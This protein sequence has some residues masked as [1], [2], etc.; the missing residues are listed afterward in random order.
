MLRA[1]TAR[2]IALVTPAVCI[3]PMSPWTDAQ[4]NAV[5]EI[6]RPVKTIGGA[7]VWCIG[8]VAI[9]AY[10]RRAADSNGNLCP[11]RR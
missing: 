2:V 7:G 11:S 5:I 8:I 6:T 10:G 1:I 4:E 3:T 9:R